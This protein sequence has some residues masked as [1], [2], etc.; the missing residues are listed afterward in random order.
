MLNRI[1]T[2]LEVKP[3]SITCQWSNG[4]I[5]EIDFSTK[6]NEWASSPQSI[7]SKLEN[8]DIFKNVKLDNEAHTL[9][10]EN[11][12]TMIDLSGKQI[13]APLGFC[14][15]VLSQMSTQKL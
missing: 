8:E 11:L 3:Y 15:D 1:T 14:P 4:E 13:P 10:W 9:Y 6:L 12:A 7:Y 2:I 5:R